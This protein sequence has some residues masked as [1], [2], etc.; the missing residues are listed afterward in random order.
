MTLATTYFLGVVDTVKKYS[1]SLKFIDGTMTLLKNCSPVST[2]PPINFSPV[3][4][5][6]PIR[7]Y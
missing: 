4:T 7:Q 2:T 6:P 3:S 5:T 1:K